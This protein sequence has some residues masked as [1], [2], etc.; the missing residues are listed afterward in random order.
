VRFASWNVR[1]FSKAGTQVE[2]VDLSPIDTKRPDDT[3]EY[4]VKEK[5]DSG[6]DFMGVQETKIRGEGYLLC[7]NDG[8]G[9]TLYYSGMVDVG[10]LRNGVGII[11]KKSLLKDI[12]QDGVHCVSD[13]MMWLEGCFYGKEMAVVSVYAPT[14]TSSQEDK[15]SFYQQLDEMMASIPRIYETKIVLGD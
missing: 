14:E 11:V 12:K 5:I 1:S 7:D 9:A 4:A 8:N 13:R 2:G 3:L 15:L 10:K 6:I